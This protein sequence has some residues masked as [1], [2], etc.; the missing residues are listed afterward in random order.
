VSVKAWE[1]K[2]VTSAW[3]VW[4][5]QL[6][7]V[8][9]PRSNFNV[10]G[11]KNFLPPLK[12]EM[13]VGLLFEVDQASATERHHG[14]RA[15]RYVTQRHRSSHVSS[16]SS[17]FEASASAED[18]DGNRRNEEEKTDVTGDKNEEDSENDND[19]EEEDEDEEE[20]GSQAS[21]VVKQGEEKED[22]EVENREDKYGLRRHDEEEESEARESA[23]KDQPGCSKVRMSRAQRKHLKK[24]KSTQN[25]QDEDLPQ[26]PGKQLDSQ[27]AA[28]SNEPAEKPKQGPTPV[29]RGKKS[30]LKKML[31]Y[32][33]QDEEDREFRMRLLGG[34][35]KEDTKRKLEEEAE[36]EA[37]KIRDDSE[38][39]CFHCHEVGHLKENCPKL[40]KKTSVI[41][42][43][44]K[45]AEAVPE[46]MQA[47][48]DVLSGKPFAED[49]VLGAMAM[50]G[51]Y[52]AV[53]N[54][55]FKVKITPGAMKKGKLA[56]M[57]M[58]MFQTENADIPSKYL[59]PEGSKNES[60]KEWRDHAR[61]IPEDQ[62]IS[63]LVGNAK[64]SS[65]G[66]QKL[67]V[68][69]KKEKKKQAKKKGDG[70]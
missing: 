17:T 57:A 29:P 15:T 18:E 58:R 54:F 42:V 36:N 46:D 49:E 30:K 22:I 34:I 38:R 61:L 4:G 60:L 44:E 12:L 50:C 52:T 26:A 31:K 6:S 67:Q 45:E 16:H 43:T 53:Q 11:V 14:E 56:Q 51:P 70:E 28:S 19:N 64:I 2:V 48:L 35:P 27:P 24:G 62:L 9:G 1:N 69:M 5:K 3:W 23:S 40:R 63:A 33:D 13:G 37:P 21:P 7:L 8:T 25:T 66:V 47:Q 20:A 32:A 41:E 10:T 39:K 68:A 55:H 59:I 65:P